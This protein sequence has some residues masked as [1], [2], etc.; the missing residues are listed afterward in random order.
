MLNI[1]F[2]TKPNPAVVH[3]DMPGRFAFRAALYASFKKNG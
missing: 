2:E 1:P 3:A